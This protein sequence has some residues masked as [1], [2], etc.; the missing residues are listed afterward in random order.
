[1]MTCARNCTKIL[2]MDFTM[3][4][5]QT[6]TAATFKERAPSSGHLLN[7]NNSLSW[8]SLVAAADSFS[9]LWRLKCFRF[10]IRCHIKMTL[11]DIDL[12]LLPKPPLHK[13]YYI[14]L[15]YTTR[16]I[17]LKLYVTACYERELINR[18]F[19][20]LLISNVALSC[21]QRSPKVLTSQITSY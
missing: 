12:K 3:S 20:L 2:Q 4:E 9:L 18:E 16:H 8:Q 11:S 15:Y 14:H 21:I 10:L 1:M 17:C 5:H 7:Y 13:A 19:S 6:V